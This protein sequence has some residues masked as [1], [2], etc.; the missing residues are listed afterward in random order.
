MGAVLP[1]K[2]DAFQ[3]LSGPY[4]HPLDDKQLAA[5]IQ[6]LIASKKPYVLRDDK[7]NLATKQSRVIWICVP[8][9]KKGLTAIEHGRRAETFHWL[10]RKPSRRIDWSKVDFDGER[11]N[12]KLAKRLR[13]HVSTVKRARK[14]FAPETQNRNLARH[15]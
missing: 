10:T 3:R 7:N 13:A 14:Q 15:K 11:S 8:E 9:I 1:M 2:T 5:A 12:K 6:A 4:R